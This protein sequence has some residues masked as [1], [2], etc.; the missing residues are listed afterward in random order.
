[1]YTPRAVTLAGSVVT[2]P[3]GAPGIMSTLRTMR[4]L[5]RQY[6]SDP[7]IRHAAINLLSLTSPRDSLGEV[8]ALFDFVRDRIRYTGDV[9]DTETL[10]TPDKTLALGAGDCDDK[11]VLLAALLESVGYV[12]RFIV[13]GY[14]TPGVFEHVYLA[15]MIADGTFV[16]L[17][18]TECQSP[19][20]EPPEPLIYYTEP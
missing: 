12:T 19:G 18:P 5:V 16:A 15:A 1:M 8:A 2:I 9:L 17:D 4:A 3:D 10:T 20:Q 13:T 11:A 14:N 6:R 7:T